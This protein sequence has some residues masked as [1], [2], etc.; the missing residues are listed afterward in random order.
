MGFIGF[1]IHYWFRSTHRERASIPRGAHLVPRDLPN[2]KKRE[3]RRKKRKEKEKVIENNYTFHKEYRLVSEQSTM[4]V[5]SGSSIAH[6]R[7]SKLGKVIRV[8]QYRHHS[9]RQESEAR[10]AQIA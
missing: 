5:S 3:E 10:E 2:G 7:Y 1:R 8:I 9:T 6:A 4:R